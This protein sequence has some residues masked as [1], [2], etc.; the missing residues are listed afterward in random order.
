VEDRANLSALPS[1]E[2]IELVLDHG[3]DAGSVMAHGLSSLGMI[4]SYPV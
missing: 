3:F 2:A 4:K 1:V